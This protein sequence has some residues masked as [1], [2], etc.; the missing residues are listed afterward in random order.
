M[1]SDMQKVLTERERWG[2][3]A[4]NRKAGKKIRPIDVSEDDDEP[5]RLSRAQL[6]GSKWKSFTDVLGPLRRFLRKNVDRP[7]DKVYSEIREHLDGRSIMSGHLLDHLSW[8][9]EL[10][11]V[12]EDG[13]VYGAPRNRIRDRVTGFYVHPRTRLLCWAPRRNYRKERLANERRREV[14]RVPVS[15]TSSYIKVAGIWYR[16]EYEIVATPD[17]RAQAGEPDWLWYRDG[18]R[19]FHLTKKRQCGAKELRERRLVNTPTLDAP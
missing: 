1:R 18:S 3:S 16:A 17:R 13:V 19:W 6:Y 14:T 15:E 5:R 7:W 11:A 12:L 4:P 8:E 10:H 2:S 9:V